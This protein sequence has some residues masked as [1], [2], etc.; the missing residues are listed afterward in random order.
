VVYAGNPV[1]AGEAT[2]GRENPRRGASVAFVA[3]PAAPNAM[4]QPPYPPGASFLDRPEL[5]AIF[6]VAAALTL[7]TLPAYLLLT[8]ARYAR[9]RYW[10]GR[11]GTP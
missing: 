6:A 4:R 7:A 10:A 11:P 2:A 8:S 1:V 3:E 5:S 9:V